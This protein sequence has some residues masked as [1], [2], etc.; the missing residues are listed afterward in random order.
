MQH[1]SRRQ[2]QNGETIVQ[3]SHF[4]KLCGSHCWNSMVAKNAVSCLH[5]NNS[6]LIMLSK[7]Q[8]CSEPH[9]RA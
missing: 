8:P 4:D 1:E 2:L 5:I 6:A 9:S 3:D 7:H